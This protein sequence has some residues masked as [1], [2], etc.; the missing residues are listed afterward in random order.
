MINA[1]L[2]VL[3][4]FV[5]V[6]Y[7]LRLVT[8]LA[9]RWISLRQSG[10]GAGER[11]LIVGAGEGGEFATWLLKRP[12]FRRLYSVVG[13]ADDDPSKQGLRFDG[14]MVLG[15]TADIPDLV[16]RHDVGVIFYAISKISNS[17]SE[18]ILLTC[19]S[20][21][22]HLVII[23]DVLYSLHSHLTKGLPHFEMASSNLITQPKQKVENVE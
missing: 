23:S 19:K 21:D 22:A 15:T 5:A 20:T 2:L 10:Y 13:F 18:R 1:G 9:S 6:R 3:I 14:V 4:S 8:G 7:R 17:D 16:R 11:V 12:D